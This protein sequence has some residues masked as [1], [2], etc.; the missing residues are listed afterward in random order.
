MT[1]QPD[2]SLLLGTLVQAVPG[3]TGAP[4]LQVTERGAL[5]LRQGRIAATGTADRVRAVAP[6]GVAVHD[7]GGRLILPGF[8][9]AHIHL[10]Q[11]D[12]IASHGEHLLAWLERYAF[13]VEEAF[14]DETVA[15]EV[16]GFFL[17]ELLR[18]GTTTAVVLGSVHPQSVEALF[19]EAHARGLRL[20]A[21]KL[22][23]DRNCPAALRDGPGLGLD[24]SRELIRRWHGVGRLRYALTPR[25]APACSAA[26]L[27]GIA[28]LAEQ[29]PDVYVHS[30]LAESRGELDWVRHVF[31]E[32]ASYLDV[33][34]DFGLLRRRALFAHCI[35]LDQN[36]RE[37]MATAGAA[38]VFCPTSNLFLG[39]GLFD[40]AAC[41]RAGL[42][43]ALGTDV[44]A[45]TSFSMLRTAAE[46]YKVA[47]L[48]GAPPSPAE[49]LYLMTRGGAEALYLDDHIG[50][51]EV[52]ME[53][54][55]VVLDPGATPLLA[56]RAA[57]CESVD[58]LLFAILM[59]GDD[60]HVAAV[61]TGAIRYTP[62][63]D[64]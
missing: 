42:R 35:H 13:P 17:E 57:C 48:Q 32:Q 33:Y 45:G 34:R 27:R 2:D 20:V 63:A 59:L 22:L 40:Y 50:S 58:E 36:E 1:T 11:T 41:R 64:G 21:G 23:M 28:K 7:H 19:R 31:P 25:F 46:A 15:A 5:W 12:I 49:L 44:G 14:S 16:S 54:D 18:N 61:Y 26:Q 24:Q 3:E 51:L 29:H 9:D 53:A 38:A 4:V 52:G 60:R 62:V 56:R 43:I 6:E 30:H 47:A 10:P 55:C 8:V 37:R 39:S